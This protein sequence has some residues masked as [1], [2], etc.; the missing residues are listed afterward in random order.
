MNRIQWIGVDIA[1]RSFVAAKRFRKGFR[2][3]SFDLNAEGVQAF[4]KWLPRKLQLQIVVEATG[5][6]WRAF[7]WELEKLAPV[8]P[9]A[10][11]NP[12]RV[13]DFAKASP[14]ASKTDPLDAQLLIFFAETFD[15]PPHQPESSFLPTTACERCVGTPCSC[16]NSW[17]WSETSRKRRRWIPTLPKKCCFP[18]NN[19]R[20]I[21]SRP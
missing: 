18:S 15:P 3:Q 17:T 6:Y 12:R 16:G 8:L 11:V 1:K 20:I 9:V 13:R 19:S 5:P 7:T 10:V 14:Q 21:S 4:H 2:T